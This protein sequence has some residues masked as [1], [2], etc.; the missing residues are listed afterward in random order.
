MET[1]GNL[2]KPVETYGDLGPS[3]ES[4]IFGFLQPAFL[5]HGCSGTLRDFVV[6]ETS[7][8][9]RAAAPAGRHHN[10]R[11][12]TANRSEGR[13][14]LLGASFRKTLEKLRGMMP[15]PAINISIVIIMCVYIYMYYI[16][17]IITK[18][19]TLIIIRIKTIILYI[20]INIISYFKLCVCV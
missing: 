5:L 14:A 4:L 11:L 16:I 17:I 10:T 15:P 19:I 13:M 20:Y 2:W 12:P 18:I 3:S 1:C 6:Q 9:H 8:P 7:A